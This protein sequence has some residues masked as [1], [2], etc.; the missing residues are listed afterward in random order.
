MDVTS[1][2]PCVEIHFNFFYFSSLFCE[3]VLK[4]SNKSNI[5]RAAIGELA[6]FKSPPAM[7]TPT[8]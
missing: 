1:N 7:I 2:M 4:K 6:H 5:K 8:F 3:L